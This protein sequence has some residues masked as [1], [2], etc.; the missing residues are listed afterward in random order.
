VC[1]HNL[2]K[3]KTGFDHNPILQ[4]VLST[5]SLDLVCAI[6]NLFVS[7]VSIYRVFPQLLLDTCNILGENLIVKQ[8]D[9]IF[10]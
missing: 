8:V 1:T 9:Y 7:H 3:S 2:E 6:I 5:F 10:S 4:V